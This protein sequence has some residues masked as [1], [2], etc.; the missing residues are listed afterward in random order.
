MLLSQDILPDEETSHYGNEQNLKDCLESC[1]E[2]TYK[3]LYHLEINLF[4]RYILYRNSSFYKD[5]IL[6]RQTILLKSMQNYWSS[7]R[8][9]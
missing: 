9:D 8:L 1:T 6:W 5:K 2:R 4:G 7:I 3:N